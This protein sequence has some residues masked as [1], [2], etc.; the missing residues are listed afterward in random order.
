MHINGKELKITISSFRDARDL[1]KA[2]E[3][4]LK[5][6]RFEIPSIARSAD[7]KID[8]EHTDVDFSGM[9]D[10]VLGVSTSDEVEDCLFKC[11]ERAM[12]GQEKV[13][14]DFFER[15]ENREHFYPIMVEIIKVNVGPFFKAL[16]SKFGGL[17]DLSEMFR[18]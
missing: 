14:R 2:I 8:L 6:T 11:A 1:E 13:D 12:V 4:A 5:G 10:M 17:T 18:K 16:A 15:V 3:R 9:V 7:G